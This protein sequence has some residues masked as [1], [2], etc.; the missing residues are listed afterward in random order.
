MLNFDDIDNWDSELEKMNKSKKGRKFVYPDSFVKTT[1]LPKSI[2][3]LL[4]R[5]TESIVREHTSNTILSLPNYSNISR[6]INRLDI[7]F[8]MMTNLIYLMLIL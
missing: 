6:I 8:L 2:L 4:Y 3:H 5:Q 7:K 1:W